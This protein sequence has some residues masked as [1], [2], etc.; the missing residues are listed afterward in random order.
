MAGRVEETFDVLIISQIEGSPGT[1]KDQHNSASL[2]RARK[3][4]ALFSMSIGN[5]SINQFC[6]RLNQFNIAYVGDFEEWLNRTE[7][8]EVELFGKILRRWQA[9][10]PNRMRRSENDPKRQNIHPFLE[11][12]LLASKEHIS[13]LE[14]FSVE[15]P[16]SYND[17]NIKAI[18]YLWTIFSNLSYQ[19]HARNGAAGLVGISKAVLLLT[20][21]RVGPAFDTNVKQAIGLYPKNE[22]EWILALKFVTE[23]ITI[24]KTNNKITSLQEIVS[25]RYQNHH[26]GRIYDMAVW[27]MTKQK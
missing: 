12:L 23:D 1:T 11:D 21:G 5:Y 13:T 17:R 27:P 18:K 19:G 9:C 20:D 24:F 25:E 4:K 26:S 16:N 6:N 22:D 2:R 10:R 15:D 7:E 3:S 8:M 14:S